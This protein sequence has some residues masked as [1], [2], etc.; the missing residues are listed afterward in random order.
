[1]PSR[2]PLALVVL[3]M[4]AEESLHPYAMR[5]RIADRAYDQLPGV[6]ATSLYDVVRRLAAAGLIRA[7]ETSR[8]G[9][10]PE[11][12]G[13]T[14]TAAGLE[15]LDDWAAETLADTGDRDGFASALAFMYALGRD[16]VSTLLQERLDQLTVT[17]DATEA[18]LA[19]AHGSPIFLSDHRY[20]LAQ[21]RAERD[22][23]AGFLADLETGALTWPAAG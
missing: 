13:Y 8:D 23:I 19:Q 1:M 15:T 3:G 4:L 14:V 7:D 20:L 16:R 9:N 2:H 6:R 11:R 5:R 22:W 17:V 18:A 10:R 21:R 12:T